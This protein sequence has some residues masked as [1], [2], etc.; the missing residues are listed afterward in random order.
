MKVKKI[1]TSIDVGS[2][3][4]KHQ[5]YGNQFIV[6]KDGSLVAD[7]HEYTAKCGVQAGWFTY[8]KEDA[9]VSPE[10]EIKMKPAE[11]T[12]TEF[13]YDIGNYYGVGDLDRLRIK[14]TELRRNDLRDFAKTRLKVSLPPNA[15]TDKLIEAIMDLVIRAKTKGR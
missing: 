6:Q 4:S 8:L 1:M 15:G 13:G 11:I 2:P 3:G 7:I 12:V 10:L 5:L 14:I 9:T